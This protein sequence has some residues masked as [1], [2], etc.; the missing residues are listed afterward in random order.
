MKTF[1]STAPV[2]I[3]YGRQAD[4]EALARLA[5]LDSHAALQGEVLVGEVAG[6]IW[7]AV[8]LGDFS[9]VADPFRPSGELAFLLVERARQLRR[10]AGRRRR[11]GSRR[12]AFA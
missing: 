7:A 8:S 4:S 2:T 11:H 10:H 12:P 6:E 1:E 5:Q 3:R 9:V